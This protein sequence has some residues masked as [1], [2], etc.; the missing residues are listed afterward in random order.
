[1]SEDL[2]LE[3]SQL[4]IDY[5]LRDPGYN[6]VALDDSWSYGWGKDVYLIVDE[7]KFLKGMLA[8]SDRLHDK[9]LAFGMYSSTGEMTYA[10]YAGS[11]DYKMQDATNFASWGV[12]HLKYD[13]CYHMGRFGTPLVS[14]NLFNEMA[15]ARKST[16]RSILYSLCS[17]FEDY[18]HTVGSCDRL[19]AEAVGTRRYMKVAAFQSPICRSGF[20]SLWAVIVAMSCIFATDSGFKAAEIIT[21]R[22]MR[23]DTHCCTKS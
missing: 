12:D 11:L 23:R 5:G 10:R 9:N 16:R 18:V 13:S 1:V 14:F 8:V 19:V 2:L 3:T 15:K 6:P 22:I 4:L 17:W 21:H 7:A 20:N